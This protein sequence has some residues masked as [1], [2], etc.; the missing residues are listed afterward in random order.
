MNWIIVAPHIELL[1]ES[2]RRLLGRPIVTGAKISDACAIHQAEFAL[3]SHGLEDDPILN[4]GNE[5]AQALF[6]MSWDELTSMPSRLTAE[7][8]RRE[9][10]ALMMERVTRNGFV[11]DYEG[12]RISKSGRR[13]QIRDTTIWNVLDPDGVYRGQAALIPRWSFV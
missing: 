1:A 6:E 2:Y 13:F 9:D 11:T 5:T 10:R 4:Y 8:A 7:P 3:V 12:V